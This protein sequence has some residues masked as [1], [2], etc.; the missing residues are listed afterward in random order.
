MGA[1]DVLGQTARAINQLVA[2]IQEI[3][4][5]TN[6][7]ALNAAIEAARAGEAGRG[8]AVVADEV[9]QL[10]GNAH[11]ASADIEKL[12][13]EVLQQTAGIAGM[14]AE[15]QDN[16]AQ[17]SV[18]ATQIDSVVDQLLDHSH[19]MQQTIKTAATVAYLNTV[20]IDHAVWKNQVYGLINNNQCDHSVSD[21][22]E[23]RL[24]KWYYQGFGAH[25]LQHLQSFRKLDTPHARVHSAGKEA[26]QAASSGNADLAAR[27]LTS[28]ED[29]S[30]EVVYCINQLVKEMGL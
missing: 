10:A 15:N 19:S 13:A 5:Q 28:M 16:A 8:F 27:H 20:K 22:T 2:S 23:C 14:V 4:S 24:G 17:I 12:V 21:H 18:S 26:L 11:R 1:V 9:R 3:S 7:L 25:N 29:A 30:L 6:L